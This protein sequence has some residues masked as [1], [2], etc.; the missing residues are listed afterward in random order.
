[1]RLFQV[2]HSELVSESIILI[3]SINEKLKQVQLDKAAI[4][5]KQIFYRILKIL[6][7]CR[8]QLLL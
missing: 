7:L 2:C 1:M 8:S 5:S 3:S 4:L 6:V